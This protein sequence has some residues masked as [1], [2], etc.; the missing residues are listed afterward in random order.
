MLMF[1]QNNSRN[2][3]TRVK[4]FI[5]NFIKQLKN[6]TQE[7]IKR[8]LVAMDKKIY[9][10]KRSLIYLMIIIDTLKKSD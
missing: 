10:P 3:P 2:F 9:T 8:I 1:S 6:Y 7:L 4:S 5:N